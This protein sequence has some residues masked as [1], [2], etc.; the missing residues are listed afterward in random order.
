MKKV[1]FL[2]MGLFVAGLAAWAVPKEFKEKP[3][4]IE[5]LN[6]MHA[7]AI[8]AIQSGIQYDN[9]QTEDYLWRTGT[10]DVVANDL[11]PLFRRTDYDFRKP[12]Q[13]EK[14]YRH[15]NKPIKKPLGS[16][17]YRMRLTQHRL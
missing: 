8:V 1:L 16:W 15:I 5:I 9:I 10:T 11:I 4:K 17:K 6:V 13:N 14:N 2:L 3:V 12:L 7:D